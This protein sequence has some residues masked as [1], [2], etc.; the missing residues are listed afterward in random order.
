MDG[1]YQLHVPLFGILRLSTLL[2]LGKIKGSEGKPTKEP[3][4]ERSA[5]KQRAGDA[6]LKSKEP[7]TER[8][9][10]VQYGVEK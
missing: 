1:L 2:K 5:Q 10:R 8:S 3:E 4:T 9:P 7:G 6:A